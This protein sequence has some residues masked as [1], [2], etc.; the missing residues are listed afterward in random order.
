ML[1]LVTWNIPSD[2]VEKTRQRFLTST[3]E[4]FGCELVGRWHTLERTGVLILKSDDWIAISKWAQ[5]WDD[6]LDL[7]ISP[8]VT[9][10]DAAKSLAP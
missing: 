7:T 10:Q 4:W 6:L 1:H 5:Q 2:T 3:E 8:C 9:D